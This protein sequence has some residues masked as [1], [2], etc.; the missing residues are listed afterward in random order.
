M[1]ELYNPDIHHPKYEKPAIVRDSREF[2]LKPPVQQAVFDTRNKTGVVLVVWNTKKETWDLSEDL[3][4]RFI[5]Q[6]K[7]Q[8]KNQDILKAIKEWTLVVKNIPWKD[9]IA[10]SL[11]WTNLDYIYNNNWTEYF[12][13]KWRRDDLTRYS[14]FLGFSHWN[15]TE[16]TKWNWK[17]KIVVNGKELE[18]FSEESILEYYNWWKFMEKMI[19]RM[20]YIQDNWESIENEKGKWKSWKE[21]GL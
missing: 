18:V 16:V 8:T 9:K 5:E 15:F 4:K 19:N 1:A 2:W 12:D 7:K 21:L 14:A 13:F 6:L 20:K 10:L 17:Y 3:K 11:N